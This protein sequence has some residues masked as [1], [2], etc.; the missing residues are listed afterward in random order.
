MTPTLRYRQKVH[1]V[2]GTPLTDSALS[3]IVTSCESQ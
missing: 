3:A 1:T 2:L